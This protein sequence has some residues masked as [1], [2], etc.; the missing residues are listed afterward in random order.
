VPVPIARHTTFQQFRDY[1]IFL[2]CIYGDLPLGW[3]RTPMAYFERTVNGVLRD[4]VL[5]KRADDEQVTPTEIQAVCAKL[6][7]DPEE[8][9]FKYS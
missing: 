8:F 5:K 7:I 4:S 6:A 3:S 2:G 9:G 1:L